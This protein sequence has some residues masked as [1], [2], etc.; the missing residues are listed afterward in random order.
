MA[1]REV[2]DTLDEIDKQQNRS[3]QP[4]EQHATDEE[5][6]ISVAVTEK[7]ITRKLTMDSDEGLA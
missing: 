3:V 1:D 2:R 7:Q 5:L 4:E 6:C